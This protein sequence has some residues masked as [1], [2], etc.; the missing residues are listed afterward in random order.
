[1][2]P[3]NRSIGIGLMGLGVIGSGVAKVLT[4]K[5]STLTREAGS[6]LVLKKV[7]EIDSAKH[8]TLGIKPDLFTTQFADLVNDPEIKIVGAYRRRA[9]CL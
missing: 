8:G 9:S 6:P 3:N 7:L 1:M 2:S 4:G 5:P